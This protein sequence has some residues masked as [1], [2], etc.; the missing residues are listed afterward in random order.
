M[1]R[2]TLKPTPTRFCFAGGFPP[3]L[4]VKSSLTKSRGNKKESP[5]IRKKEGGEKKCITS[6]LFSSPNFLLPGA[7]SQTLR[8]KRENAFSQQH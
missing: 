1:K 3:R 6:F 8:G 7:S 2:L 5:D 4:G